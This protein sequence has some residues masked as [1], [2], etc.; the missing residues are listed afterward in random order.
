ML[1]TVA[2][3]LT[4]PPGIVRTPTTT[5]RALT[6]V[7]RRAVVCF[8]GSPPPAGLW[9]VISHLHPPAYTMPRE[10]RRSVAVPIDFHCLLDPSLNRPTAVCLLVSM[11]DK[12][13]LPLSCAGPASSPVLGPGYGAPSNRSVS[14]QCM[15]SRHLPPA[16]QCWALATGHTDKLQFYFPLA[17]FVGRYNCLVGYM[18][19]HVA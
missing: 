19:A 11:L 10:E 3:P 8:S 18:C 12:L 17:P 1:S 2:A 6:F 4:A 16:N 13:S 7:D 9:L 14:E 15:D 5:I